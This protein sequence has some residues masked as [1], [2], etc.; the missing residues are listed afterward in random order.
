MR[1]GRRAGRQAGA[2]GDSALHRS[3]A[4]R[5]PTP[6]AGA[7]L[8]APA[9]FLDFVNAPVGKGLPVP[10]PVKPLIAIPTTAGT[11]SETTGVAIFDYTG[12]GDNCSAAG[13][14]T[15]VGALPALLFCAA[16]LLVPSLCLTPLQPFTPRRA[17]AAA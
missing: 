7:T 12:A 10:G 11:G 13:T 3:L 5:P 14:D 2:A 16:L 8:L 17:S 6:I 4:H 9:D 1:A 15:H